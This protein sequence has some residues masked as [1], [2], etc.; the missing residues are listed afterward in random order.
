[1]TQRLYIEDIA[2]RLEARPDVYVT[3]AAELLRSL[4]KD[5]DTT[6]QAK[7]DIAAAWVAGYYH[8]GYTYDGAYADKMSDE[9]AAEW[10]K[11]AAQPYTVA[12]RKAS[13]AKWAKKI[14]AHAIDTAP[15]RVEKQAGNV[16]VPEGWK[17]VPVEPTEAMIA[18]GEA[19]DDDSII[20]HPF[21]V[22]T[23]IYKAMLSA[24]PSTKEGS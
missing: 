15:G 23:K 12:D 7:E 6:K 3:A 13:E 10:C 18:A 20:E 1:M 5:I 8:A 4:A 17:L 21:Y 22:A 2:S 9:F 24:A 16:Q 19:A 11:K 14:D